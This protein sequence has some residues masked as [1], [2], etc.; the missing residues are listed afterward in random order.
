MNFDQRVLSRA[1][2]LFR[3]MG[4]EGIL[5]SLETEQYFELNDT[6][7]R[8]FNALLQAGSIQT[9]FEMLA[10]EYDTDADDLRRDLADLVQQLAKNR[11]IDLG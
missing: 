8:M 6:G 4:Q 11:L 1:D 9:A 3:E 7:V 5:L 10:A 2:V